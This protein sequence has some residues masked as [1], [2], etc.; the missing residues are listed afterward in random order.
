MGE[1][2]VGNGQ[3]RAGA[4][5]RQRIRILLGVGRKD[6]GDDLGFIQEPFGKQRPDRTIDQAAGENFFFGGTP[7]AFDKTARDLPGGVGVLA[8]VHREGE[9]PGSRFRIV[10][11]AGGDENRGIARSDD[12]RAVRLSGHLAGFQGDCPATQIDFNCVRH[13]LNLNL[14]PRPGAGPTAA[15]RTN[16]VTALADRVR[17]E[18]TGCRAAA[19]PGPRAPA[20]PGPMGMNRKHPP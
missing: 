6:H 15:S 10:G 4:D 17:L 12:N 19:P 14:Q 1:R 18:L 16:H 7:L 2:N 20:R 3:R 11:H 9:E 13:V 5:D 8:V